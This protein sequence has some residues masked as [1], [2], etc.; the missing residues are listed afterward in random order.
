M[1][2]WTRTAEAWSETDFGIGDVLRGMAGIAVGTA[3]GIV[4]WEES[5]PMVALAVVTGAVGGFGRFIAN[6][7]TIRRR[8]AEERVEDLEGRLPA[9]AP[10]LHVEVGN[11]VGQLRGWDRFIRVRNDGAPATVFASMEILDGP[12]PYADG[13]DNTYRLRWEQRDAFRV[14]LGDGESDWARFANY[15][16][17]PTSERVSHKASLYRFDDPK[18]GQY[19]A[20]VEY[21]KRGDEVLKDTGPLTIEITVSSDPM[22]DGGSWKGRFR[23]DPGRSSR[24]I[25]L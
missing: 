15:D 4:G 1:D 8:R 16:G 6:F 5:G 11:K 23:L 12:T 10:R 18:G 13:P 24:R 25:D 9:D 20:T 2:A 22:P 17:A 3:V 21:V 19:F 7:V 14:T